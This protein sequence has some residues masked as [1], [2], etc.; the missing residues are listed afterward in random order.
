MVLAD[1]IALM[2]RG[3]IAQVGLPTDIYER[4]ASRWVARFIGDVNLFEGKVAGTAADGGAV[5]TATAGRLRVASLAGAA[6]G[7]SV[8]VALRPEKIA[9]AAVAPAPGRDN[10]LAGRVT[11]IGYRGDK[12]VYKIALDSGALIKAAAANVAR[13]DA[14]AIGLGDAVFLSWPP[15]AGVVLSA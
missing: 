3:R 1:R 9:L 15:E 10:A 13:G 11:E 7:D 4:P 6:V 2:D 12:S 14:D 5:E 8:A